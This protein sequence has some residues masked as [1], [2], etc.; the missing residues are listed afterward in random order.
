[1][2]TSILFV[3]LWNVMFFF[4]VDA[5]EILFVSNRPSPTIENVGDIRAF[6]SLKYAAMV[7]FAMLVVYMA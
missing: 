2:I 4:F 1:M 6:R 7:A 5:C 3:V